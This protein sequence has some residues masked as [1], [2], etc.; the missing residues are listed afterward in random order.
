MGIDELVDVHHS[1]LQGLPLQRRHFKEIEYL[2]SFEQIHR[3]R[4]R[5]SVSASVCF[6]APNLELH[7]LECQ[8]SHLGPYQRTVLLVIEQIG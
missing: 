6:Y 5:H 7:G 3:I 1:I 8:N 4:G 2:V